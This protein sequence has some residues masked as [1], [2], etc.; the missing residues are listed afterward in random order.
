M[1]PNG[2]FLTCPFHCPPFTTDPPSLLPCASSPHS[3]PLYPAPLNT[4]PPSHSQVTSRQLSPLPPSSSPTNIQPHSP[5]PLP[6]PFKPFFIFSPLHPTPPKP[7]PLFPQFPSFL[8]CNL[9]PNLH[10]T[11]PLSLQPLPCQFTRT[12]HVLPC[13]VTLQSHAFALSRFDSLSYYR[14]LPRPFTTHPPPPTPPPP[15]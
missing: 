13:T 2:F 9:L 8:S 14:N 1:Y 7:I 11:P 5:S 15:G 6:C 10:P 12:C 4:N 3:P